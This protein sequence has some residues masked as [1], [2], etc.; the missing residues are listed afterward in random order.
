MIRL[1]R[2]N[3]PR[4]STFPLQ[5]SCCNLAITTVI[6]IPF[7]MTAY[8]DLET[9]IFNPSGADS[10]SSLRHS[11]SRV[12]LVPFM[13]LCSLPTSTSLEL[14]L[15]SS[16]DLTPIWFFQL[17]WISFQSQ[18]SLQ[19]KPLMAASPAIPWFTMQTSNISFCSQ[20]KDVQ[21]T[22]VED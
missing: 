19:K 11:W 20:L 10:S 18:M 14:A 22:F 15:F 16:C 6:R 2:D 4:T 13:C 9:Y 1:R 17:L 5:Y 8:L 7:S 21:C 12:S 3:W